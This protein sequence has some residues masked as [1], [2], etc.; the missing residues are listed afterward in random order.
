MRKNIPGRVALSA[1]TAGIAVLAAAAGAAL[2]AQAATQSSPEG[3]T[4]YDSYHI[5]NYTGGP[6]T[7]MNYQQRGGDSG[8]THYN[9]GFGTVPQPTIAPNTT[10]DF[11]IP[12]HAT[13]GYTNDG[14]VVTY[15]THD[16]KEISFNAFA[17]YSWS[18]SGSRL[19]DDPSSCLGTPGYEC[20]THRTVGHE[21]VTNFYAYTLPQSSTPVSASNTG[22]H[23]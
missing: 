16:G 13:S 7:L 6:L 19:V 1:I 15:R 21:A 22:E 5:E 11:S 2:P 17:T 10:S 20:K 8:N 12:A 23:Q 4:Y 3:P 18:S 9:T 14:T